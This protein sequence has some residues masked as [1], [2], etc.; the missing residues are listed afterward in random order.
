MPDPTPKA[1]LH[2]PRVTAVWQAFKANGWIINSLPMAQVAVAALDT[3]EKA[4]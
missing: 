4:T 1:E 3:Y 2:D